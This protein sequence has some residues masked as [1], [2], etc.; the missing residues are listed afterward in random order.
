MFEETNGIIEIDKIFLNEYNYSSNTE[1]LKEKFIESEL[2]GQREK[3]WFFSGRTKYLYKKQDMNSDDIYAEI[4]A[5]EIANVLGIECAEYRLATF[6][7]KP[8]VV[9]KNFIKPNEKLVLGAELLSDILNKFALNDNE[10]K[11]KYEIDKLEKTKDIHNKLNNLEDMWSIIELYLV[12]KGYD[13]KFIKP[14]MEGMTK[15]FFFD[16]ITLQGD[17]HISNWGLI[18]NEKEKTIRFAPL[19]DNS[20]MCGLN[21]ISV[22]KTFDDM[23]KTLR[24]NNRNDGKFKKTEEQM[25]NLLYHPKLLFSVSENDILNIGSKKR[26]NNLEILDYFLSV[27]SK[28]Y[29][30]ILE[31][32]LDM[33]EKSNLKKIMLD[34]EI[35]D[36]IEIPV[37][38][39]NHII[40]SMTLNMI[41]L[42]EKIENYRMNK[43]GPNYA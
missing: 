1:I 7:G 31:Y 25:Y 35:R 39:K 29:C 22:K 30:D 23:I 14:I 28:E 15:K 13:K 32:C 40:N 24:S 34:R 19:F 2:N 3:F 6:K 43:G 8:G 5:E 27:S 10:F 38:I 21:R 41:C 26:K 16:I 18:E 37:E 20:N 11:K 12:E 36:D 42:R 4:V 9:T 33:I 17:S